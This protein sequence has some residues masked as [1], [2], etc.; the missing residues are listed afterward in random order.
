LEKEGQKGM[1]IID[2]D[3]LERCLQR[4]KKFF[5]RG[6]ASLLVELFQE[7]FLKRKLRFVYFGTHVIDDLAASIEFDKDDDEVK[8]DSIAVV[9]ELW[10]LDHDMDYGHF[11]DLVP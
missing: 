11:P 10:N 3:V 1:K 6:N 8:W 2:K 7:R 4:G 9:E 5:L